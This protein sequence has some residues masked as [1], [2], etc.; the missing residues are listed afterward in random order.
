[1]YDVYVSQVGCPSVGLHECVCVVLRLSVGCP[2][3]FLVSLCL[4]P[5]LSLLFSVLPP[6]STFLFLR[7]LLSLAL[8]SS[9]PCSSLVGRVSCV[10]FLFG[11]V[12][13]VCCSYGVALSAF[14]RM[15]LFVG[16]VA[17]SCL[18]CSCR[19]VLFVLFMSRLWRSRRAGLVVWALYCEMENRGYVCPSSEERMTSKTKIHASEHERKDDDACERGGD[20]RR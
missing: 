11:R 17:L 2:S 8:S 4:S 19:T 14:I 7:R 5:S 3:S 12:V 20:A 9:T 1:M 16:R 15:A 18:L 6:P 13:L 10:G